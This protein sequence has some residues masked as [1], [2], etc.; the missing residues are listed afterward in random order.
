VPDVT[1]RMDL[2]PA[3]PD[4]APVPTPIAPQPQ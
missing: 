3:T 2:P 1:S 4:S